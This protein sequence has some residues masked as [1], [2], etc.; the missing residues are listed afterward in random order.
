M[1]PTRFCAYASEHDIENGNGGSSCLFVVVSV[2][3]SKRSYCL[4]FSLF[5]CL[6]WLCVSVPRPFSLLI[7]CSLG[8]AQ[9]LFTISAKRMEAVDVIGVSAADDAVESSVS[10]VELSLT[11]VMV[12]EP[13]CTGSMFEP[14]YTGPDTSTNVATPPRASLKT[15]RCCSPWRKEYLFYGIRCGYRKQHLRIPER[16]WHLK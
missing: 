9:L 16:A 12:S 4:C 14:V 10:L 7:P 1:S 13:V 2:G 8:Y 11:L 15:R 5:L 6:L 3:K